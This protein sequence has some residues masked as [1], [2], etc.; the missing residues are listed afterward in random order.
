LLEDRATASCSGA[1]R[2]L[3][4]SSHPGALD[5]H[6]ASKIDPGYA[7]VDEVIW[8]EYNATWIEPLNRSDDPITDIKQIMRVDTRVLQ[9]IYAIAS[10]QDRL[11]VGQQLDVFI[12]SEN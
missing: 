1:R 9:V 12:R 3:H 8:P 2:R 11:Y 10:G 4:D 7:V 6:F 5:A